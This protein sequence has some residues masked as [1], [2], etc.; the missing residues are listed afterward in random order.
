MLEICINDTVAYPLV[1]TFSAVAVRH[2]GVLG[3]L[4]VL[5]YTITPVDRRT[6]FLN[7]LTVVGID[8]L[9]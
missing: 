7:L 3:L 4:D 2:L 8:Q 9:F 1:I 6:K 5:S